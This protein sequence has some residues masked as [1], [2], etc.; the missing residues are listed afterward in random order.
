MDLFSV[1]LSGTCVAAFGFLSKE[2]LAKF[3]FDRIVEFSELNGKIAFHL[4]KN[5]NL[6]SNS[7]LAYKSNQFLTELSA[8]TI[9]AR[10]LAAHVYAFKHKRN[11]GLFF[12]PSQKD[13]SE[14]GSCLI[15]ISNISSE[16][17]A[18]FF[19]K[20]KGELSRALGLKLD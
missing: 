3:I 12:T 19:S 15:G 6:Y 8:A 1:I 14:A 5:A 17:D 20:L 10:T 16:T 9:E 13:L 7:S 4:V 11:V 18:P 2:L